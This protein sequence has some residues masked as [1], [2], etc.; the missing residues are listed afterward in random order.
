MKQR[1][2]QLPHCIRKHSS[3]RRCPKDVQKAVNSSYRPPFVIY[4]VQ[5]QAIHSDRDEF[6]EQ[7][8]AYCMHSRRIYN[9]KIFR[10]ILLYDFY[11]ELNP[12]QNIISIWNQNS[13]DCPLLTNAVCWC[14]RRYAIVTDG[15]HSLP[16]NRKS[17]WHTPS[18][19]QRK[20]EQHII[21]SCLMSCRFCPPYWYYNTWTGIDTAFEIYGILIPKKWDEGR[22]TRPIAE[23]GFHHVICI[24]FHSPNRALFII[25]YICL[26][27][28][29]CNAFP[30]LRQGRAF[31]GIK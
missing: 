19:S 9:C 28:E 7:Q 22:C 27:D 2:R 8:I 26:L 18:S 6:V 14:I 1:I 3:D 20:D 5:Y 21:I 17:V 24:H 16:R 29:D 10:F 30:I 15:S 11:F 31:N 12:D 13:F 4:S 23:N 25:A